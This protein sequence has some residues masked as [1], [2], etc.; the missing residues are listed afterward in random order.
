MWQKHNVMQHNWDFIKEIQVHDTE[1]VT[2]VFN[3]MQVD[4]TLFK[5]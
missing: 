4:G 5:E 2:G 3:I 1:K